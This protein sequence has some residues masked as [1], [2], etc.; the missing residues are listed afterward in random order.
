M[1]M[2]DSQ[3]HTGRFG[4]NALL[5]GLP[6]EED[7]GLLV[8]L[9]Q[10]SLTRGM[11]LHRQGEPAHSIYFP[12]GGICTLSHTMQ[13]GRTLVIATVGRDGVV[14]PT[15]LLGR[16]STTAGVQVACDRALRMSVQ[17]FRMEMA[18]GRAFFDLMT[19]HAEAL[20]G[21]IIRTAACT[22]LH[23]VDERLPRWLLLARE[24]LGRD[25]LPLTH[26]VLAQILGVRRATV[27]L[28]AQ[29][30]Q[31]TGAI[32]CRHGRIDILDLQALEAVACE[33]SHAD[34]GD[35][36]LNSRIDP[37]FANVRMRAPEGS[38]ERPSPSLSVTT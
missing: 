15:P 18:R 4:G 1:T 8:H 21:S 30:L 25:E 34:H 14:A 2:C 22:G 27:T 16:S 10:V 20:V 5:A 12:G 26:E 33:C 13:D 29:S 9:E 38:V 24:R 3:V 17:S 36:Y 7:A 23:T 11:V 32:R 19:A 28:A 37:G 31:Q 6:L 35:V